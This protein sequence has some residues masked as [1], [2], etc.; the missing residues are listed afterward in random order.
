RIARAGVELGGDNP[1]ALALLVLVVVAVLFM[2]QNGLGAIVVV[3]V[4]TLPLLLSLRAAP[5]A[6]AGLLLMGVS[7]GGILNPA[8]WTLYLELLGIPRRQVIGFAL[9]FFGA[10]LLVGLTFVLREFPGRTGSS[11]PRFSPRW[12]T[13][14]HPASR[15]SAFR[16]LAR[17]IESLFHSDPTG[18]RPI[19]VLTPLL[20]ILLVVVA[21]IA[22]VP[23]LLASLVVAVALHSGRRRIDLVVASVLE[24]V[25][26]VLPVIAVLIGLGMLLQSLA[27]PV[28]PSDQPTFHQ[29]PAALVG[30]GGLPVPGASALI[31]HVDLPIPRAAEQPRVAAVTR[32]LEPLAKRF[33]PTGPWMYVV[34]FALLAPLALFRGPLDSS[35]MGSGL[36]A[37]MVGTGGIGAP[38]VMGI[39][40]AVGQVHGVSDPTNPQTIW[41]AVHLRV[42]AMRILAKTLP[43]SLAIALLGLVLSAVVFRGHFR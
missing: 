10:A 25:A 43:Y 28:S 29:A 11:G 21:G 23:A 8:G 36:A 27:L 31:R 39:V 38:L 19:L 1:R 14:P 41:A 37:A 30:Q 42:P 40:G 2:L 5:E 34:V 20:P 7:L 16:R 13:V 18:A 15:L 3:G 35:G 22:E 26:G 33:V 6:C 4:V 12:I 32:V 17:T 24:G 9:P